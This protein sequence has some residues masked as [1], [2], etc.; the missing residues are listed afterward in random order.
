MVPGADLRTVGPQATDELGRLVGEI[1]AVLEKATT[2]DVLKAFR[3][4]GQLKD[5][6]QV[7][8]RASLGINSEE[9]ARN[10]KAGRQPRR[11]Q[12]AGVEGLFLPEHRQG[13]QELQAANCR[14][15]PTEFT[16]HFEKI[17]LIEKLREVR[18]LIGFTRTMSPR[19]FDSA[20]EL[21]PENRARIS[22]KDPTWLPAC[23]TMA[24]GSS[25]TS[26]KRRF[27]SG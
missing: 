10:G 24:K 27:R 21:P 12:I 5:F 17:V 18:A 7:Q 2:L 26:L 3:Q 13:E 25:F 6:Q 9:A 8:R 19:D 16:K 11:S 23:E 1:W 15:P 4:I 20:A 14:G 22:R